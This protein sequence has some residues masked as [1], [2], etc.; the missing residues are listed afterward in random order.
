MTISKCAFEDLGFGSCCNWWSKNYIQ[1]FSFLLVLKSPNFFSCRNVNMAYFWS[2]WWRKKY[3]NRAFLTEY[4]NKFLQE[5]DFE[6]FLLI[7]PFAWMWCLEA[8]NM[9]FFHED[10]RPTQNTVVQKVSRI[11]IHLH[12]GWASRKFLDTLPLNFCCTRQINLFC[13]NHC[14]RIFG[15]SLLNI[16]ITIIIDVWGK[17]D[18]VAVNRETSHQEQIRQ[19][20][21]CVI[22]AQWVTGESGSIISRTLESVHQN[23]DYIINLICK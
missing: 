4:I 1:Y 2:M 13:Q 23:V 6:D 7:P 18:N 3:E 19:G 17:L 5:E 12:Y 8:D 16:I 15:F 20:Q 11:V 22:G 9:V 10:K 21:G 14:G